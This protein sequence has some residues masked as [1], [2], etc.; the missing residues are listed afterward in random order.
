L[1][2]DGGDLAL[3][4]HDALQMRR[5]A[6]N[7]NVSLVNFETLDM[8]LGLAPDAAAFDLGG[9]SE[10]EL[11]FDDL[12]NRISGA[13]GK[14]AAAKAAAEVNVRLAR[15][16]VFVFLPFLALTLGSF[17][18]RARE[19][20]GQLL[21]GVVLYIAYDHAMN[22]VDAVVASNG[23]A[24]AILLW[25][26][27]AVFALLSVWLFWLAAFH[28]AGNT[29]SATIENLA[30]ALRQRPETNSGRLSPDKQV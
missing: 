23:G 17:W 29:L 30:R 2:S 25:L 6:S 26:V 24:P 10:S 21:A 5:R 1:V 16:A 20:H 27:P 3:R 12:W 19:V 22:F 28:V 11:T 8:R 4:L 18:R 14:Q 13:D 7:P 9:K 15:A